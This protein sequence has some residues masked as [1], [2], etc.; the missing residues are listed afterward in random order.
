M[1]IQRQDYGSTS[2]IFLARFDCFMRTAQ[3]LAIASVAMALLV[4]TIWV[5]GLGNLAPLWRFHWWALPASA[6][7]ASTAAIVGYSTL[8][9]LTSTQ[10]LAEFPAAIYL[11][12]AASYTTIGV[13]NSMEVVSSAPPWM[14]P[15]SM[16]LLVVSAVAYYS[17][18]DNEPTPGE[19][20]SGEPAFSYQAIMDDCRLA[21]VPLNPENSVV[22]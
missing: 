13:L 5:A 2:S 16:T 17:T 12:P 4:T 19:A 9:V 11:V 21:T 18:I 20:D 22:N 8:R 15:L 6:S 1:A 14:G 3:A 10:K 7:L